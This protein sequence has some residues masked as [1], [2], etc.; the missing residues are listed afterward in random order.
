[1]RRNDS[2]LTPKGYKSYRIGEFEKNGK[3]IFANLLVKK[4]LAERARERI[5]WIIVAAIIAIG[6]ATGEIR[7]NVVRQPAPEGPAPTETQMLQQRGKLT[8]LLNPQTYNQCTN[9]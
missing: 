8:E 2:E 3:R 6:L 5:G 9:I 4:S 1:M 7:C